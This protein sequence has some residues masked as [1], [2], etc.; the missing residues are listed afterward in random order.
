MFKDKD[1][2]TIK[3]AF[4]EKDE[5]GSEVYLVLGDES[6]YGSVKITPTWNTGLT[7]QGINTVR[8]ECLTKLI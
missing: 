3:P 2:V 4:L 6:D 5:T 7:F 1:L 8:S